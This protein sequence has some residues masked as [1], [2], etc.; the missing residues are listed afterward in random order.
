[1]VWSNWQLTKYLICAYDDKRKKKEEEEEKE[2][3]RENTAEVQDKI[4]DIYEFFAADKILENI[5]TQTNICAARSTKISKRLD[6]W[7]PANEN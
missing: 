2:K 7:I 3:K 4:E 1:M 6:K 5:S